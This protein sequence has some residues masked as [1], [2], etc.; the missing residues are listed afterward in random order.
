MEE[1]QSSNIII[2]TE[3]ENETKPDLSLLY[4]NLHLTQSVTSSRQ[5]EDELQN[6][7]TSEF[8]IKSEHEWSDVEETQDHANYSHG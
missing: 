7:L 4:P 8:I 3:S 1:T 2:K 6:E 5:D